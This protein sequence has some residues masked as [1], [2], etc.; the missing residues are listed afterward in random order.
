MCR[1]DSISMSPRPH[2]G[3]EGGCFSCGVHDNPLIRLR[4]LLS[5]DVGERTLSETNPVIGRGP[6]LDRAP[7]E[8]GATCDQLNHSAPMQYKYASPRRKM[9]SPSTMGGA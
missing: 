7:H 8:V 9:R 3:G 6:R 2:C 4:P 1:S 5:Q